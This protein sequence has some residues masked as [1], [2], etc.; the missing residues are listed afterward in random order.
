VLDKEGYALYFS[1]A[2]IPY[3][4]DAFALGIDTLPLRL[5]AYRHIGLYAYRAAFLATYAQLPPAP[6]EEY[7][8][9][10]QLRAL[11]HGHKISTLITPI[12]PHAGV[13]TADD[14]ARVRTLLEGAR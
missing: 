5:P 14:L 3:P 9:L 7:E 11:W 8:A 4:R 6:P 2:P 12:A 10:E 1:R 13:D